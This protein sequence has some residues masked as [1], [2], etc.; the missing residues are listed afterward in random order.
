MSSW[1]QSNQHAP[2][3]QGAGA[4]GPESTTPGQAPPM[5][6][7]PAAQSSAMRNARLALARL[8][9]SIQSIAHPSAQESVGDPQHIHLLQAPLP[10]HIH[11]HAAY[12][13]A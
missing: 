10:S 12:P 2:G 5:N 8:T 6:G 1:W 4:W 9:E 3:A 7:A 11:A 13:P